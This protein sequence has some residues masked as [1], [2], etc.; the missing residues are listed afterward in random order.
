MKIITVSREF[1]SGGREV[2]KRLADE[3]GLAYY[4]REIITA[5]AREMDLD[6]AYVERTLNESVYRSYPVTFAHTLS[7]MPAVNQNAPQLLARQHK[8][9]KELAAKGP[10]LIVGRGA[11]AVLE[12][13][14]PFKIFVYA[15]M[16]SKIARCRQKADEKLTDKELERK[17]RQIDKGRSDNHDFVAN[18][19]WGDK[20]GYHL[21]LN[22]TGIRIK[23]IIAPLAA[24]AGLWFAGKET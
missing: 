22:S 16:P 2:G 15:D 18:Y 4:D 12:E 11:D 24:Y 13:H 20:K 6:E 8:I 9:I 5:I 10:C 23:D 17:I 14:E 19:R 3:L 21:C 1:G 7:H